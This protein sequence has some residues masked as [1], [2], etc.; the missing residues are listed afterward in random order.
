M[1]ATLEAATVG[2]S[3][4]EMAMKRTVPVVVHPGQEPR[5]V[6]PEAEG[7]PVWALVPI[8]ALEMIA[9]VVAVGIMAVVP[10]KHPTLPL[11]AAPRT[12]TG[13]TATK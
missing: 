5:Q 7:A 10:A 2:V 3:V 1:L 8:T 11:A 12:T 6:S 13:W 4:V 9:V